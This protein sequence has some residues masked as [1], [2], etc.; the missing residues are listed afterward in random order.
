[1][2]EGLKSAQDLRVQLRATKPIPHFT[3]KPD[4]AA[5]GKPAQTTLTRTV[6]GQKLPLYRHESLAPGQGAAGPAVVVEEYFTCLVP[7][8]WSFAMN[9]N[10][11]LV[12]RRT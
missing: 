4:S 12:L 5:T 11:D 1:V 10:H 6:A 8:G 7:A 2:P 3:L 9:D